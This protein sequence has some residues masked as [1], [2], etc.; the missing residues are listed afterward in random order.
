MTED[1]KCTLFNIWIMFIFPLPTWLL[2]CT[3]S[4]WQFKSNFKGSKCDPQKFPVSRYIFAKQRHKQ[5]YS[6]C[7]EFEN[8]PVLADLFFFLR[9][10]FD[11]LLSK[12][13]DV[14][15]KTVTVFPPK[16]DSMSCLSESQNYSKELSLSF[17]QSFNKVASVRT[18]PS[19]QEKSENG[20]LWFTANRV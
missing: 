16:P 8:K 9:Q 5:K 15:S 10:I 2:E 14:A 3:N 17:D 4:Y 11:R 1:F 20:R 19:P 12:Q 6:S 7:E 13:K 18:S